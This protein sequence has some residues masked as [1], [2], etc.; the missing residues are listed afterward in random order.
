MIAD[1]TPIKQAVDEINQAKDYFSSIL[2]T[3]AD[4]VFVKNDQYRLVLVNDAA[5]RQ[6]GRDRS[7]ILGK[8]DSDF[9][10]AEQV[11]IFR[12]YDDLVLKTGDLQINQ[13]ELTAGSG[14]TTVVLSHKSCYIDQ[15]G[16]RFVVGILRDITAQKVLD[17]QATRAA[18]LAAVGE[19]AAGV[20]HEINNPIMGVINC[21]QLLLDRQS[22]R[23]EDRPVLER[24]IKGGDRVAAIV[25]SLLFFSRDSGNELA[26]ILI[27]D[28]LVDVLQLVRAQLCQEGVDVRLNQTEAPLR[29]HANP[30]QVEQL[31]LNLISNARHALNERYAQDPLQKTLLIAIDR[32]I[33]DSGPVC[34]I[35]VRDNGTGIPKGVR[36]RLGRPFVTTKPEGV[37]TGLG[38]SIC[39]EIV[40]RFSG[41]LQIDSQE[42][43]FTEVTIE[44]PVV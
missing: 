44:F 41:S 39:Q 26:V 38:L 11:E 20:A 36:E 21:A 37:G 42:G 40:K 31:L 14:Q 29:I 5:C 10:P 8:A 7:E 22:V 32:A 15:D 17:H 9:F 34:R 28:L 18:Q 2:N 13:E 23:E 27:Q 4:P 12:R 1:I 16:R 25:R 30:Q 35:V 33:K 24:V 43:E 19:L 6:L 3:I